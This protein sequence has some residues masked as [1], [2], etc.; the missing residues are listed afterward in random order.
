MIT[1]FKKVYVYCYLTISITFLLF[2]TPQ[3][4]FHEMCGEE[5]NEKRNYG[6]VY[7]YEMGDPVPRNLRPGPID[8]EEHTYVF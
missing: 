5:K 1:K 3:K 7:S 6:E 8:S 2:L 4:K